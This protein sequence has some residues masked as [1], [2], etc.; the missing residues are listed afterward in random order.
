MC[1]LIKTEE[2]YKKAKKKQE[3]MQREFAIISIFAA[4]QT[5]HRAHPPRG[6]K[7][8]EKTENSNGNKWEAD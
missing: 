4:C 2:S 8:A 6:I 7:R 5:A 3:E 1:R